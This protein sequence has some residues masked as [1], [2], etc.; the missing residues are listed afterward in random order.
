MDLPGANAWCL[1]VEAAPLTLFEDRIS[2]EVYAKKGS[3]CDDATMSEVFFCDFSRIMRYPAVI[4]EADLGEC[5]DR[6]AH[7]PTSIVMQ[8]WGVPKSACKVVL[9]ALQL[10]RF[11]LRT[12]FRE[13]RQ[14]FVGTKSRPFAGSSQGIGWDTP[15]FDALR[16]IAVRRL[17]EIWR[18]SKD[19]ITILGQSLL[20]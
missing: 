11:Y 14:L 5:Y 13:S 20:V 3:H 7:P 2:D 4:T 1:V 12:G 19:H 8:S 6:M 9:T 10:M 18:R 16:S 17:Q 15:D